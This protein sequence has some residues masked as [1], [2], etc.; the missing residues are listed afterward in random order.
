MTTTYKNARA[1]A[2]TSYATMY[3]CPAATTAIIMNCIVSNIDGVSG[4]DASIQYLDSSASNAVTRLLHLV[5]VPAKA[6]LTAFDKIVLE[7]GDA[8]QVKGSSVNLEFTLSIAER[9]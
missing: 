4:V 7:A 6:S 8:L 2:T 5:T 3:T 9:T 1:V